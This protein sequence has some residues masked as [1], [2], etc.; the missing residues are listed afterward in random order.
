MRL[1]SYIIEGPGRHGHP[2]R[3]SALNPENKIAETL[4]RDCKQILQFYK[5]GRYLYRGIR[6][7]SSDP[8]FVEKKFHPDRRPKDTVQGIHDYMNKLYKE[9]FGWEV[10]SGISVTSAFTQ[11]SMYGGV[12]IFLPV[13][14]FKFVYNLEI[15][16]FTDDFAGEWTDTGHRWIGKDDFHFKKNAQAVVDDS[17]DTNLKGAFGYQREIMFW[18]KKYY[19]LSHL[20]DQILKDL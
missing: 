13:D 17:K 6:V 7:N 5:Q 18:C 3:R 10:R 15:F 9:K 20:E 14:G 12:F 8:T 2:V 1:K 16:D 4:K 11:A 19:L